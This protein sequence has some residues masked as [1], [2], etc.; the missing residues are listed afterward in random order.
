MK[1]SKGGKAMINKFEYKEATPEK[2]QEMLLEIVSLYNIADRAQAVQALAHSQAVLECTQEDFAEIAGVSVRT[3]RDWKN[4]EYPE[5]Y[6][7][8]FEKY[9][10]EPE[11]IDVEIEVEED[12][13]EAVY[14]NLLA[15]LQNPKTATKD[16][17]TILQYFGISGQE[18]RQYAQLRGA[19]LRGFVRDNEKQLIKDEDTA[20]LVKAMLAES[21]FLYLGTEKTKGR[22][23]QYMEM[24]LDD[25]L[26]RLE[27]M[28]A[29]MLMYGL[30]NGSINP[31]FVEM[32][33][34]L[35]VLK[36]ASGEELDTKK[37]T[38]EFDQMDGKVTP[39]K[40]VTEKLRNNLIEIFGNEEGQQLYQSLLEAKSDVAAKTAI[41]LPPYEE[42]NKDY[43]KQL[44]VFPSIENMPF[45]VFL[46]KLDAET[47][48]TYK[49]KYQKYL[50]TNQE[51]K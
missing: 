48:K 45:D 4:K 11:L 50:N 28:T 25:P 39:S 33:Q 31:K 9:S 32:A 5:I 20:S 47:D 43:N 44:R 16:L 19:T 35:R 36:M 1:L 34:T 40:P 30:W 23:A 42:I 46:A 38:K 3:L 12:A 22:T 7:E 37:S 26:V 10:P 41:T 13:L 14:Q 6:A 18:L 8:A 49:D 21:N 15:R 17:A 27:L 24:D 51:E 2:K 29:G